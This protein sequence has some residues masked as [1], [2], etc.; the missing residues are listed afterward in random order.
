MYICLYE[1]SS[2][3]KGHCILYAWVGVRTPDIS[4]IHLN[5]SFPAAFFAPVVVGDCNLLTADPTVVLGVLFT[6]G[7]IWVLAVFVHCVQFQVVVVVVP[8]DDEGVWLMSCICRFL[9]YLVDLYH[10]G[11]DCLEVVYELRLICLCSHSTVVPST[12]GSRSCFSDSYGSITF[13][14]RSGVSV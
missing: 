2:V 14:S 6:V 8:S 11:V 9:V 13:D 4:L 1:H 7:G 5:G 10:V 3:G 12:F